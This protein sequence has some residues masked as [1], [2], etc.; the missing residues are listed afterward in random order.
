MNYEEQYLQ[1]CRD[2][3]EHGE[4]TEDRTGT[5]TYSV[6]GYTYEHDLSKGFPLLTTKKINFNLVAGELLWI[7]AGKTDLP[8][9]RKYQNKPEGSH[10]IWSDDFEKFWD[11]L[12]EIDEGYS[13][14]ERSEERGGKIYGEQLR[15]FGCANLEG[16]DYWVHDQLTTLID[17]IKAVKEDPS[18][19]MAR[20]LICAFWNPYDHTVGDKKW[21]AL[22]ACHTDFQCIVRNGKLNLRFAMR[23]NDVFLGNPYNTASYA[24]LAHILAK[25][26]GLEVGKLVYFGTDVHIYS[27][28]IEQVE[29]Q[30]SRTPREMPKLILPE[31]ETLEDLLKL[32]GED[33]KLEGY[34]P[35]SFIKAPQAS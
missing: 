30:L 7:L 26:T 31:F 16:Q 5:G 24:L 14:P 10:T 6:M 15:R 19:P 25:L 4:Y 2:I 32:T 22:P 20:R 18:H 1:M 21:C 17:N 29:E 27:T 8:S 28:H 13:E 33:F 23:S 11:T 12:D 34:N 9:L 35:H 3:L